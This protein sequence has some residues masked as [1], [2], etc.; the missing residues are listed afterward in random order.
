[1]SKLIRVTLIFF[2]ILW[3][4]SSISTN[5]K[6]KEKKIDTSFSCAH[7][8]SW[9]L[10]SLLFSYTFCA[11]PYKI[12]VANLY[13]KWTWGWG[14]GQKKKIYSGFSDRILILYYIHHKIGLN[15]ANPNPLLLALS[16]SQI[17]VVDLSTLQELPLSLS[18]YYFF[19]SLRKKCFRTFMYI[20]HCDL[21]H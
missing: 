2:F 16:L 21:K 4:F 17:Q 1:M 15:H 5:S 8:S 11:V 9:W 3:V 10:Y 6:K 12:H 14:Y 18:F 19:F 20:V 7:T 13:G